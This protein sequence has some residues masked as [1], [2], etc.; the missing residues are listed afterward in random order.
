MDDDGIIMNELSKMNPYLETIGN[1]ATTIA[2]EQAKIIQTAD[3][4][5]SKFKEIIDERIITDKTYGSSVERIEKLKVRIDA[6]KRVLDD[7]KIKMELLR[8]VNNNNHL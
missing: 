4:V 6:A 1:T 5:N 3:S 8:A 2:E 7:I